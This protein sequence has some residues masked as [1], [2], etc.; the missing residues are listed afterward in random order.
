MSMSPGKMVRPRASISWCAPGSSGATAEMRPSSM[1][2]SAVT[3]FSAVTTLPP[4]TTRSAKVGLPLLE[5]T[6]AGIQGGAHIFDANIF[7]GMMTDA[8]G[9]AQEEHGGGN[10]LGE[11]HG[12]VSRAAGHAMHGITGGFDGVGQSLHQSG[13]HLNCGL[14]HVLLPVN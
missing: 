11:K 13:I 14:V 1:A 9:R 4:R 2:M 6:H 8:A 3:I 12:I 10:F 5:E 7:V